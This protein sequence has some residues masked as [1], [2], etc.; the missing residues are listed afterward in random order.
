M[1]N[2][3]EII[4]KTY[5]EITTLLNKPYYILEGIPSNKGRNNMLYSS[6]DLKDVTGL[7]QLD[8]ASNSQS[9]FD[10]IHPDYIEDYYKSNHRLL[11]ERTREKRVYLVR[12]KETGNFIPVEEVASSRLNTDRNCY[13]IYCSLSS[14]NKSIDENE[15]LSPEEVSRIFSSNEPVTV[16]LR[17]RIYEIAQYF[18]ENF[19]K[20]F[21]VNA[22]RF[23]AYDALKNELTILGDNQ[24]KKSKQ[25]LESISRIRTRNIVPKYSIDSFLFKQFFKKEYIIIEDK[26]PIVQILKDHTDSTILKKLAG[27]ATKI[28]NINSFGILPMCC[29]DGKIVG[30]VTFGSPLLYSDEQKKAIFDFTNTTAGVFTCTLEDACK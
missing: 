8:L 7:T 13:E 22:C 26:E 17:N 27:P 29:P 30:L 18:V 9:F 19:T 15:H 16:D 12:N 6:P 21:K 25:A 3:S 23:Y 2:Q 10:S 5:R 24:N 20:N 28:Y 14:I 1:T 4:L 11:S